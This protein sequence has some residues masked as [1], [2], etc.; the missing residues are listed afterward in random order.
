MRCLFVVLLLASVLALGAGTYY[1][2]GNLPIDETSSWRSNRDG[3]GSSPSGFL[4][5]AHDFIVQ[6]GDSMDAEG[7]WTLHYNSTVLIETGGKITSGSYNH[8]IFLS[9]QAG[10]T[11]EVTHF[12]YGSL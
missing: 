8:D 9:L 6:D 4:L 2:R 11:Y 1:S 5:T 10:A 7:T 12:T 3:S